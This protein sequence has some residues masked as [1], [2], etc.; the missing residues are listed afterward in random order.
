[1]LPSPLLT[2]TTI[3]TLL[4]AFASLLRDRW[5]G[6]SALMGGQPRGRFAKGTLFVVC[7]GVLQR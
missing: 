6:F 1:M 7:R 3:M 4:L 5:I 2:T